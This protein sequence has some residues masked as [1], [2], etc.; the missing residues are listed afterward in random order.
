[1]EVLDVQVLPLYSQLNPE[2]QLRVFEK[3]K[4]GCR[5]IVLATNVAETSI[6]IPNIRYVVDSGRSKEK[7]FDK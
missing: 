2:K 3:P 5:L 7:L 1:V 4:E 6:T